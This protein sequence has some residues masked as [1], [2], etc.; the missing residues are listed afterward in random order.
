M[1][2]RAAAADRF[3]ADVMLGRLARWLRLAGVDCAY[4]SARGGPAD[5]LHRAKA[6]SRVVLTR[7]HNLAGVSADDV[8]HLESEDYG[9]QLR[10]VF[11]RFDL[12]LEL[13]LARCAE[14]NR[15]LASLPK[16]EAH[17]IVPLHVYETCD[18]FHIC[19]GCRRVYW[20]GTHA[21]SIEES[22][23]RVLEP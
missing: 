11:S 6:E 4:M 2:A 19:P 20:R 22:L 16:S 8:F 7:D 5:V 10:E 9:E 12:K 13:E 23:R 14:C 1:K 21:E 18:V 17:G 3:L 15:R